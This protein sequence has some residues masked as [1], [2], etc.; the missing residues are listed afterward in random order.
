MWK[1]LVELLPGFEQE[2]AQVESY[3]KKVLAQP[4]VEAQKD[5]I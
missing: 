2:L 5:E 1:K 3:I 4:D